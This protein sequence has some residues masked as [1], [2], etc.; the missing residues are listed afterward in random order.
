[1]QALDRREEGLSQLLRLIEIADSAQGLGGAFHSTRSR[2]TRLSMTN[3]G[4]WTAVFEGWSLV[5]LTEQ[6]RGTGRAEKQ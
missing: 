2:G 1:M 5:E 4:R 6:C 3:C